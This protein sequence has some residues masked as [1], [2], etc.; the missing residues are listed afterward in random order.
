MR[1]F[2]TKTSQS[3]WLFFITVP[4]D[5]KYPPSVGGIISR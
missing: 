5:V 2:F 1:E 3:V 4:R